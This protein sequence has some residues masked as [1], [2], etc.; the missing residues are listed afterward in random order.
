[1]AGAV[2]IQILMATGEAVAFAVRFA[3]SQRPVV[4]D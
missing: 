1:M 2:D 4:D 3:G